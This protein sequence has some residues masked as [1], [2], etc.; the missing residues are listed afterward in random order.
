MNKR[1]AELL[2]IPHIVC[3]SHLMNVEV[4]EMFENDT[5][6]TSCSLLRNIAALVPIYENRTCLCEKYILRERFQRI[7][8]SLSKLSEEY[9]WN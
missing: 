2:N 9:L 7:Y 6:L 1:I 3:T 8:D 4:E 5:A